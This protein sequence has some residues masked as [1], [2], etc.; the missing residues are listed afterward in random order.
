MSVDTGDVGEA[1]CIYKLLSIGVK[2]AK[3][4]ME[5]CDVV[6]IPGNRS[7]RVQVKTSNVRYRVRNDRPSDQKY[8]SFSLAKGGGNKKAITSEDCDVIALVALDIEKVLFMGINE[9]NP[10]S[11]KINLHPRYFY[12]GCELDSW[13]ELKC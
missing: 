3:V 10:G 6:A 2:A 9:F 4:N 12:T 8:Y 13:R 11:K 1:L 7:L 5:V